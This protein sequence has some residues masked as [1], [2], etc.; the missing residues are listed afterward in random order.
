M[1]RT[2]RSLFLLPAVAAL[3]FTA[4]CS[5]TVAGTPS[6][7]PVAVE[8]E[9][10]GDAV[11]WVDQVCQSLLPFV[12][13]S[14]DAPVPSESPDPASLVR[15]ISTYLGDAEDAAGSAIEG[16]EAAGPAPVAGG[17][18]VVERLSSSLETYQASF[19]DARTRIERVDVTDRQALLTE[20]PAAVASLRELAALPNPMAGFEG[21][22]E[23]DRAGR[24]APGCQQIS[25]EFGR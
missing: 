4:A 13:A 21:S 18:E 19:R 5:T 17:D 12:R 10:S 20:V 16:M 25:R 14:G 2:T 23:L 22:P 15:A 6:A 8:A 7:D 11:A 1:P 9:G 3:A 24:E